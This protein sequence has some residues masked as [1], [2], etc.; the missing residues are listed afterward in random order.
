MTRSTRGITTS[1][2]DAGGHD[3]ARDTDGPAE[4]QGSLREWA[5]RVAPTV[6]ADEWAALRVWES[7]DVAEPGAIARWAPGQ[8]R[9]L[10]AH[11]REIN[12]PKKGNGT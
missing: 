7:S 9:A 11:V 1:T 6:T 3:L 2:A 4:P 12:E 5:A 10:L 8:R